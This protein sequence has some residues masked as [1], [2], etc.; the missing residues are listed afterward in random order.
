VELPLP[1]P[2]LG[3][4]LWDLNP[5]PFSATSPVDDVIMTSLGQPRF[6]AVEGVGARAKIALV[7]TERVMSADSGGRRDPER[8]RA[9]PGKL[10]GN[11]NRKGVDHAKD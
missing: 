1:R 10:L 4:P 9:A 7:E 11:D 6:A 8:P 5:R 2:Q 3:R